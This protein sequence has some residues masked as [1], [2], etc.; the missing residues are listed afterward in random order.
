M[1]ID[2]SPDPLVFDWEAPRVLAPG[3]RSYLLAHAVS[4]EVVDTCGVY[5]EGDVLVYPFRDGGTVTEQRVT[6][7]DGKRQGKPLWSSGEP[8]HLWAVRLDEG[9]EGDAIIE[10][11]KQALAAASW[12]PPGWNVYC[13]AG[14]EGAAKVRLSRF[15]GRR[16]VLCLDADAGSNLNVYEAGDA[17]SG[18]LRER[19]ADVSFL[20]IKARGSDGLDDV[21]ARDWEPGERTPYLA[22][23]IE[24]ENRK[25][26][27]RKPTR[28]GSGG[29]GGNDFQDDGPPVRDG[30]VPVMVNEDRLHAVRLI[31]GTLAQRLGG[32]A[33]F[34][35][36]GLVTRLQGHETQ[37][38]DRD[39]FHSTLIEHVACFNRNEGKQGVTYVASWPDSQTTGAVLARAEVFPPLTRVTRTPFLRPDGS[40]CVVPGYDGP[41]GAFLAGVTAGVTVEESPDHRMTRWAA[42]YLMDEWLGDMPFETPADRANCLAL[43]LTP[44]V[45]GL[46]PLVP[47]AVVNG[48]QMGVGKNLLA[49]VLR[50]MASGAVADPLP[51]PT[52]EDEMRKQITS[53][54]LGGADCFVF[55]E[56]HTIESAQLARALTAREYTDRILGVSRQGKF[57]NNAVWMA[58]GN[59]VQVNGDMS[60]RVYHVRLAPKTARS[61]DN[62][63]EY[64]HPDLVGWTLENRPKLITAALTVLRGW[65]AAGSP[66]FHRGWSMGSFEAWDRWMAGVTAYAGY[67]QFLEHERARRSESDFVTHYWSQHI[68]W[69][70][71]AFGTDTPF[72]TAEV[73]Q[74]GAQAPQTDPFEG[75]PDLTEV[76][77]DNYSRRLGQAYAR[78]KDVPMESGLMLTEAGTGHNNIKRWVVKQITSN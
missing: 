9:A 56:A 12:F 32:T 43:V 13:M 72:T 60:R 18:R 46:F 50:V 67:P 27:P 57:T 65:L 20:W 24:E 70:S 34:N 40:V 21:L 11:N 49:D 59:Q 10:G 17:L 16:V 71:R 58:L 3:H 38:L 23:K 54:F 22:R 15:S 52:D 33:L 44:F 66:P 8:L 61:Y 68:L 62:E 55:D 36:G 31:S 7:I 30:R 73:R 35:Y 75:P 63:R 76:K 41:T 2:G 14:C 28:R 77:G 53:V 26:A 25:P 5:S 78:K 39:V 4:E 74:K 6:V 29:N 45:R 64:R 51:M 69:L 42:E 48:L 37:A 19:G 47:L 1:S